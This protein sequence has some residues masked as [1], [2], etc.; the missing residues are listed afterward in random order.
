MHPSGCW[1]VYCVAALL[2]VATSLQ[3]DIQLPDADSYAP[4]EVDGQSGW[5]WQ[6][7]KMDVWVVRQSVIRQGTMTAR[8]DTAVLWVDQQAVSGG[9]ESRVSV[10]LEGHV[11]IDFARPGSSHQATQQPAQSVRDHTWF[12]QLLASGHVQLLAR[13]VV[14]DPTDRPEVYQR[15]EVAFDQAARYTVQPAQYAAPLNPAGAYPGPAGSAGAPNGNVAFP[16]TPAP[17]TLPPPGA[18]LAAPPS[19]GQPV[20]EPI[21]S[22]PPLSGGQKRFQVGPRSNTPINFKSFPGNLPDQT[23]TVFS[24]G[25]RAVIEGL[26]APAM[27]PVGRMVI[28]TDRLVYWGPKFTSSLSLSGGETAGGPDIPI[29]IYMEGNIVFRQGDRLIYADRMYYNATYEYGVVLAAEVF[30][31]VPDYQG[32]VRFKADVLQ[33]L[34]HQTSRPRARRSRPVRWACRPTGCRPSRSSSATRTQPVVNPLTGQMVLDPLT[35]EVAVEHDMLA[36]SRNN[37]LY[38]GGWPVFYWPVMATNLRKPNYYLERFSVKNDNV[39]GTQVLADWDLFQLLRIDEPPAGTEWLLRTDYLTERGFGVGTTFSYQQQNFLGHPGPVNGWLDAWG[40]RDSGRDDLGLNRA[41]V[42]PD[43]DWR[44]RV[45]WRHRQDLANGW[46]VTAQLGLI[47]DRNFLE[48][49]FEGEWDEWKDQVTSLELKRSWDGQ[50]LG[51][52]GQVHLNPSVSQTEWFPRLDHF[53]IGRSLLQDR[54]TW[55]AHSPSQ[56]TRASTCWNHPPIRRT[57]PAGTVLPWEQP[58]LQP[59]GGRFATRQ[60]IDLPLQLGGAKVVPYAAG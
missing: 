23:V 10:Y 12:G 37:F 5:Q 24:N 56:L 42:E 55:Y 22:P 30:T 44:G 9:Q 11:A 43:T 35:N 47:S 48:Q 51:I 7:G 6:Q 36:R 46:Q 49:Y 17:G 58:P 19:M 33:Q 59:E 14:R 28:E 1:W 32:L 52:L 29:E 45:Y 54:L 60:E 40:I 39:F 57:R 53:L 15:A 20:V 41:H 25:L 8:A 27:G 16:A 4:I 34:D 31:P 13:D 2:L 3:A 38:I 26:E 21:M 18:A 50:S